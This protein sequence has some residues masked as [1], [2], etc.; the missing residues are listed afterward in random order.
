[1]DVK[2]HGFKHAIKSTW[3]VD[4]YAGKMDPSDFRI[5]KFNLS[6]EECHPTKSKLL[7]YYQ[8][9]GGQITSPSTQDKMITNPGYSFFIHR[10]PADKKA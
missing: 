6:P 9:R 5:E 8:W 3:P 7:N 10:Y 4:L 2:N 1:M